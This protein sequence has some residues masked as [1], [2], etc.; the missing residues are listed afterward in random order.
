MTATAPQKPA[1]SGPAPTVLESDSLRLAFQLR[2]DGIEWISL[3]D[4]AAKREILAPEQPFW[5]L[6][7]VDAKGKS[8]ELNNRAGWIR[9]SA[10][11]GPTWANLEWRDP[12][13]LA[14]ASIGVH[15]AVALQGERSLWTLEVENKSSATVRAV[16]FPHVATQPLGGDGGD[17]AVIFP[18]G[19]GERRIDPFTNKLQYE[20]AYPTGWGSFQFMAHHDPA[21][22][23]YVATH[24][25]VASTKRLATRTLDDGKALRMAFIWPVPDATVAGN[26]FQ[27]SGPAVVQSFRGDWFDAA[28]I[29][30][31][32]A[33]KGARWW[34][35]D[36]QRR[37]TPGWMHD[38]AIWAQTGGT[39]RSVVA[40]VRNFAA[41][42]GV[43]TALHWYNWHEIPFDDNYPHYFP[44]K[45]GF[46]EGVAELQKTG[47][48][49]MPYI[50]GRLWDT[51]LEDFAQGARAFA[52]K[53]ERGEVYIEQY[54][55]GQK[56]A[57]MCPAT[58]FWQD[59]VN[60]TVL[61]L[62]GPEA[63]VETVRTAIPSAA[64]TGGP[65]SATGRCSNASRAR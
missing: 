45:A 21:G 63:G 15:V 29:Y 14:P 18:R 44:A 13:A 24:D 57:P 41:Y 23:V 17:D 55:S 42:M 56:L 39:T 35:A 10:A 32:W 47:V 4:V 61:R 49:V 64:A 46:R 22:G 38:V 6:V 9:V 48:R 54:G 62:L 3:F 1:A 8:R 50:N 34:P 2:P 25:P 12:K 60:R 52:T 28:Q 19:P 59:T 16:V 51:D 31:A 5:Q 53:N 11:A 58:R 33:Q 37:D 7:V 30:R 65:C 43:P 36:P 27:M 20:S 40:R 26:D